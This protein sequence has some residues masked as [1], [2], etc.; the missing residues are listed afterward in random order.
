LATEIALQLAGVRSGYKALPVLAGIDMHANCGEVLTILGRNGAGKTTLLKTIA[1]HLMLTSGSV[2]LLGAEIGNCPSHHIAK[3]GLAYV[4][5]GRGIFPGLSVRDN[6][7][8][9]TRAQNSRHALVP[10]FVFEQ[11]PILN[12]MLGKPAGS[13]S[14]GQQ[15]QLAIARALAGRPKVLLLDEPAEGI[16]PNVVQSITELL[17]LLAHKQG[18]A[19]VV[20]EQNL[21]LGLGAADRCLGLA[22]GSVVFEGP[23]DAFA[24]AELLTKYLGI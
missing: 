20:V 15:Q 22:K 4:P 13:L 1:G 16:Q 18:L 11:F 21:N 23:P 5:Q 10:D 8:L 19:V 14:G 6:L 2:N 3:A 9:G 7:T 17:K 12:Q 24:N